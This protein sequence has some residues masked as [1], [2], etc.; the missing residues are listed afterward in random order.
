VANQLLHCQKHA[1]GHVLVQPFAFLVGIDLGP[2]YKRPDIVKLFIYMICIHKGNKYELLC[3]I[4]TFYDTPRTTEG[5][6]NRCSYPASFF[7]SLHARK[8]LNDKYTRLFRLPKFSEPGYFLFLPELSRF[9]PC[10]PTRAD[11]IL[12]LFNLKK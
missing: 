7:A 8:T 5:M 9:P 10:V 1:V 12:D 4:F 6:R 3:C 2:L 11:A